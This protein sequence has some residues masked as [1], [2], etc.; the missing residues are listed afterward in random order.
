[1][2]SH[3]MKEGLSRKMGSHVHKTKQVHSK[4]CDYKVITKQ[5]LNLLN[6]THRQAKDI[7]TVSFYLPSSSRES[8]EI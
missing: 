5:Q 7:F 6:W 1:M 8:L 4:F 2:R 3:K